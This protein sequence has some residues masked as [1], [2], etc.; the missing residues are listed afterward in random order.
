MTQYSLVHF[1]AL[2]PAAVRGVTFVLQQLFPR[3][4]VEQVGLK[5]RA[6]ICRFESAGSAV[7]HLGVIN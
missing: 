1:A 7:L 2:L 5:L 6:K 3:L 4:Q